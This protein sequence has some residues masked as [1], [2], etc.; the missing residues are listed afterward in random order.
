MHDTPKPPKLLKWSRA[1]DQHYAQDQKIL[2]SAGCSFTASTVNFDGPYSWPGFVL[3]RC[4]FDH[5]I[6]LSY[7]G[8]GNEF[9]ANSVLNYVE[10]LDPEEYNNVVIVVCWSGTDRKEDLLLSTNQLS[11]ILPQIDNITYQWFRDS[12]SNQTKYPRQPAEV[13]RSWK[14]IIFLQNY[15]ENKKIK[16]GFSLYCNT[17]EP[18]FLPRRDLTESFHDYMSQKKMIALKKC[19]WLHQFKDSFFEYCFFNDDC[20]SEDLFHPNPQGASLWTDRVLLPGML[21]QNLIAKK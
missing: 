2:V 17:V 21:A 5:C 14:N 1:L 18:P 8:V 16:F 7:P 19:T 6:D 13:W 3:E 15:L 20:L 4:G 12:P 11:K 9:I 10:G